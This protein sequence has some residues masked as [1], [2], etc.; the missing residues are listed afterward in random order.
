[1][2]SPAR[3][4]PWLAVVFTTA[5][6]GCSSKQNTPNSTPG[7]RTRVV[8]IAAAA[9]L[10][11]AME[12]L[13]AAFET[14]E[15]EVQIEPTFGSSGNFYSQLSNKAPFDVFMSAD[16]AYPRKLIEQGLA[17]TETEFLY[18]IGQ[19]VV[20]VPKSSS[21]DVAK[22]G[23]Q[24]LTDASVRKVSIAN[25]EHAPYGRAAEAAM[26]SLGV[27]D[28]VK[29]RLVLGESI[30]Q[31][32]QFVESGAADV[33]IL[34]ISLAM[35]PAMRDKGSYWI[36]PADSYPRLEQGGVIL[37]WAKDRAAAEEFR[38]FVIEKRGREILVRFGFRAP[39][40]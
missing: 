22:L 35:A 18:A 38:S 21:L 16:I 9:D 2:I 23:I 37:S 36:V 11:F 4:I 34:A 29:D 6:A 20:W 40:E 24:A 28:E 32:A 1:M 10:K 26:K 27:Y 14:D 39:G 8:R 12:E 15:P 13:V 33:G 19:I 25:P 30:S 5:L 31:A 7:D 3:M 17:D